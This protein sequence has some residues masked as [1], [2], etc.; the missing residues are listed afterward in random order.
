LD[1]AG[2]E[3]AT[4]YVV[5]EYFHHYAKSAVMDNT[6]NTY[7]IMDFGINERAYHF[8]GDTDVVLIMKVFIYVSSC[9]GV[10]EVSGPSRLPTAHCFT[11]NIL[12]LFTS[13]LF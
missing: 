8:V 1:W 4:S 11:C 2:I 12:L 13:L 7:I 5:G 10:L 9:T 3:P 6:M